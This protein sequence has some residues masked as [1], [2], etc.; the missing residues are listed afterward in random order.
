MAETE[1]KSI[2]GRKISDDNV[3]QQLNNYKNEVTAQFNTVTQDIG[4]TILP[5]TDQTIKGAIAE[6]FQSASSGKTLIANAITGKGVSTNVNDSF[7][8]MATNISSISDSSGNINGTVFTLNDKKYKLIDDGNGNITATLVTYTITNSLSNSTNSNLNTQVEYGS[9]YIA[10]ISASGGYK[11]SAVTI[12]MSGVDIT[13]TAYSNGNINIAS[14][15][16]NIVITVT[17]IVEVETVVGSIDTN[18]NITLS[19]L[20]KGTYTLKYEDDTG[21]I[22]DFDII[23]TMEV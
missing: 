1:V 4:D 16:G 3:R 22:S 14:V 7:Q 18:K 12:T 23:A 13:S 20:S 6:V 2:K 5:T 10:T 17:T 8:T 9:S 21:I 15:T 11:L 19:G